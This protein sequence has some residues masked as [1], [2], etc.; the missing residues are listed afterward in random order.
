MAP[1][2]G[3]RR[4]KS[5]LMNPI[6]GPAH[7]HRTHPIIGATQEPHISE[8]GA[9]AR[10]G[11]PSRGPTRDDAA[12]DGSSDEDVCDDEEMGLAGLDRARKQKKRRR[13]TRLDNRIA[14]E[15]NLSADELREADKDVVK[16]LAVIC[17]FIILWYIFSLAI[18]L[19]SETPHP[20]S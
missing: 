3:H 10:I 4:R 19:V 13:N 8:N 6:G 16:N 1:I 2:A 9:P 5:S 18:S 12:D 7:G 15:K 17:L 20:P 11:G 14:R